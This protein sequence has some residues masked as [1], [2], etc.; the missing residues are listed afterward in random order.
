MDL[1]FN[2]RN[3]LQPTF[4]IQISHFSK[5]ITFKFFEDISETDHWWR[6]DYDSL[7]SLTKILSLNGTKDNTCFKYVRLVQNVRFIGDLVKTPIFDW[8]FGMR[9]VSLK[10]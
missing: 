2:L 6:H 9:G 1:C 4:F 7:I 10:P 5:N 8:N 3:T